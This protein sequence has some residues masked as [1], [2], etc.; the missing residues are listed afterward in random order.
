MA[1]SSKSASPSHCSVIQ[2]VKI[3]RSSSFS[4]LMEFSPF[5]AGSFLTA[6]RMPSAAF[7]NMANRYHLL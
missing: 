6:N 3:W 1:F 7:Q 5:Q 2:S 4:A